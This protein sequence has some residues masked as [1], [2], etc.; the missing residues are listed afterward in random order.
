M[1]HDMQILIHIQPVAAAAAVDFVAAVVHGEADQR[2]VLAP[3]AIDQHAQLGKRMAV[4]TQLAERLHAFGAEFVHEGIVIGVVHGDE[5]VLIRH[6]ELRG[7]GIDLIHT[8]E[9]VIIHLALQIDPGHA[10]ISIRHDGAALAIADERIK[11]GIDSDDRLF[12]LADAVHLRLSAGIHGA[13][14]DRRDRGHHAGQ[15]QCDLRMDGHFLH[16]VRILFFNPLG[17]GVR[18]EHENAVS[19]PA[20]QLFIHIGVQFR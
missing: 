13:E 10:A 15:G 5:I 1:M 18:V 7:F 4:G 12:V 9:D 14:A 6:D 16:Q 17:D 3:V 8:V 19:L 2:V 11:D 20:G